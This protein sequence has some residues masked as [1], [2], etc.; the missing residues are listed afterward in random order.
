[1]EHNSQ[2]EDSAH[3]PMP[4]HGVRLYYPNT[5]SVVG[6]V[7][8]HPLPMLLGVQIFIIDLVHCLRSIL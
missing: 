5:K 2:L 8:H 3:H 1:M 4:P 7:V 6:L